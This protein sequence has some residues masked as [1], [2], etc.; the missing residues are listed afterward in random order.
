[1]L[2]QSLTLLADGT[3]DRVLLP[4]IERLMDKYCPDPFVS[5]FAEGLSAS[6]R[7]TSQRVKAAIDLYPCDLLFIH[8]DAESVEPSVRE[9]EIRSSLSDVLNPPHLICVVPVRMTEAWLLTSEAAIRS[10]VGNP[11]GQA[12][13]SLPHANRVESVDAKEVLFKALEA[14]KGLGANRAR[15]FKPDW[16][17]HR[18]SELMP[19]LEALRKLPSFQR[20]ESQVASH[21]SP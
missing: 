20:L 1:M 14:A 6:A 16:Y 9:A 2:T 17:R 12:D 19:D 7:T 8:R 21:F 10:A 5:R 11:R 13:L 15:R 4:L 18:I 3:S